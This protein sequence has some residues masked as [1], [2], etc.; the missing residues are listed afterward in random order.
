MQL[1]CSLQPSNTT[2]VRVPL[3]RAYREAPSITAELRT[4]TRGVWVFRIA[5]IRIATTRTRISRTSVTRLML[6]TTLMRHSVNR[7]LPKS[8]TIVSVAATAVLVLPPPPPSM[9][10]H[11]NLMAL[12]I[13]LPMDSS[14]AHLLTTTLI[15]SHRHLR[16]TM[17]SSPRS[18][19]TAVADPL[20][21]QRTHM[22]ATTTFRPRLPT[23]R[24]EQPPRMLISP[25]PVL[26]NTAS[27]SK[28]ALANPGMVV[29]V[30]LPNSSSNLSTP[31]LN[32]SRVQAMALP[33]L[34]TR[35]T[36]AT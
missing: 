8:L 35:S 7:E 23:T 9:V 33:R 29:T 22:E 16:T 18:P 2:E 26:S 14:Q 3:N 15:V 27:N 21:Q 32:L 19:R 31:H 17:D 36:L 24:T 6:I 13:L 1:H 12:P 11:S 10:H 30:D 28:A 25:K 34:R 5:P 4:S 20:R